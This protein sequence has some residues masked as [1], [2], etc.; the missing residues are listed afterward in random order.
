MTSHGAWVVVPVK[1]FAD[2]KHRLSPFLSQPERAQLAQTMLGDVLHAVRQAKGLRQIVVVTHD[3][4]VADFARQ[5]EATVIDDGGANGTNAAVKIGFAEIARREGEAMVALPSDIPA[6]RPDD[7]E[8][9]LE[10]LERVGVAIAPAARDGGTNAL[11][12]KAASRI[13]PCFGTDSFAGHVAASNAIGVRP[14]V[15]SNNRLGLDLDTPRDLADFLGLD[16]GTNTDRYLRS[17][18]FAGRY[19]GVV[20]PCQ[21]SLSA[22]VKPIPAAHGGLHRYPLPEAAS[23]AVKL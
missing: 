19:D 21:S 6:I 23:H 7:I 17:L 4:N 20:Q 9:L 1:S 11:A 12:C 18:A 8:A 3:R 2:A 22:Q 14:A 10:A 16:S 13:V 5:H 15:V